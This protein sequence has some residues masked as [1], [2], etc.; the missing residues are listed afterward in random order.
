MYARRNG[1]FLRL[2]NVKEL[3]LLNCSR[4]SVSLPSLDFWRG[5]AV[6]SSQRDPLHQPLRLVGRGRP[7]IWA[8]RERASALRVQPRTKLSLPTRKPSCAP[9]NKV[10]IPSPIPTLYH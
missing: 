3:Q 8:V 1:V 5:A 6:S 9:L 10:K 7:L 2:P 4:R